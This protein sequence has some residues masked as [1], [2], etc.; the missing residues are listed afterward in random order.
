MVKSFVSRTTAIAGAVAALLMAG[1]LVLTIASTGA[2]GATRDHRPKPVIR[3]HRANRPPP[4]WGEPGRPR[5]QPKQGG[6]SVSDGKS[7]P[8]PVPCLGN[9]C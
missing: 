3:D 9:L 7:R 5:P 8:K 4:G 1:P 2:D 6:V